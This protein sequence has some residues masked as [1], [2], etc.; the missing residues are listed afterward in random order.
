MQVVY[1]TVSADLPWAFQHTSNLENLEKSI[2]RFQ[3]DEFKM[4]TRPYSTPVHQLPDRP[5]SK[6]Q[7]SRTR[8]AAT[9]RCDDIFPVMGCATAGETNA[10]E[11]RTLASRID[12]VNIPRTNPKKVDKKTC[13]DV[14]WHQVTAA[15]I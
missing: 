4:R 15:V 9:R 5:R 7:L 13:W 8:L 14:I 10:L 12:V 1:E 11:G 2:Y 3:T 6:L